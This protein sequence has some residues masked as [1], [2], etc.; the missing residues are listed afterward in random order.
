MFSLGHDQ[1]AAAEASN[2][3]SSGTN[4]TLIGIVA[5]GIAAL[6]LVVAGLTT[7]VKRMRQR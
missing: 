5:G 7:V 3:N 4:W 2:D 1:D 6:V